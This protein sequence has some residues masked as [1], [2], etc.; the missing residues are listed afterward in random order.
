MATIPKRKKKIAY[1]QN[2]G[3]ITTRVFIGKKFITI[4]VG[5]PIERLKGRIVRK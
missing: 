5:I 4:K 3:Q 1:L 2:I